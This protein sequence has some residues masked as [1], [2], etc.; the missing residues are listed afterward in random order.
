[1][2]IN[3][4]FFRMVIPS[5]LAFALTGVYSIVDGFFVGN[6]LGDNGLAAIN[7]AYP[8]TAFIQAVGTGLGLSGAVRYTILKGQGRQD[9]ATE[10]VSCTEVLLFFFSVLL[11]ILLL[12]V[13][14]PL[15]GLLGAQGAV[16][17]LSREYIQVIAIGTIFQ[18]FATGSIPFIRNLGGASFAMFTM[19]AGFGTNI[20][21]DYLFVWVYPWGMAGAALA[22]VIGQAVSVIAAIGYLFW[23]KMGFVFPAAHRFLTQGKAILKVAVAPFGLTFSSQITI[24][25]MN[26]FLM[27]YHGEQAVA[28][29]GCIAYIIVIA[30]LLLQGVGDGSQPLI[31]RYYGEGTYENMRA[32]RRLAYV[33]SGMIALLCMVVMFLLR[34]QIGVLFGASAQ[35][36]LDVAK[37]LPLFLAPLLFLSYIRIT[38]TY[39]YATEK[40]SLSYLL[41][42]AEPS[43]LF[44]LLLILSQIPALGDW[45]VWGA[46]PAAQCVTWCIALLVRGYVDRRESIAE[47][48]GKAPDPC[49]T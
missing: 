14:S 2:S 45:A 13:K 27:S 9:G 46:V 49:E 28:V 31:S 24:I 33:T 20:V 15:L 25:L 38:I 22:T 41:V 40:A 26:R 17:E 10:S 37:Y 34:G 39:L 1:M 36:N 3:R 21:L 12:A 18:V 6:Q 11:T 35:T 43:L 47:T 7:L 29:Y 8:I 4:D 32:T 5:V 30:Y 19:I 44:A 23:R 16:L 42:Y 48:G